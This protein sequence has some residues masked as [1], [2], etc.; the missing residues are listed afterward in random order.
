MTENLLLMRC[1]RDMNMSK[2][3]A[4]DVPLF[5]SLI[6][7][8]FPGLQ[9][10]KAQFPDVEKAIANQV[11]D[12]KS[13]VVQLYETYLVRHGIMII[14]P[15]GGGKTAIFNTLALALTECGTKHVI[16]KMNPKAI[17]A[18][19]MFGRLDAVSNDWTEGIFS[20]LWRK[21]NKNK[22]NIQNRKIESE[23]QQLTRLFEAYLLK[24]MD[25]MRKNVKTISPLPQ[26]NLSQTGCYVL[27]GLLGS[28]EMMA[29]T[30]KSMAPEDS[31]A[32]FES[33]FVYTCIWGLGGAL[34]SDKSNAYR[35]VFDKF[36]RDEHKTIKFPEGGL[37]YDHCVDLDTGA[38]S[39]WTSQV[40]T[41]SHAPDIPFGNISVSTVDTVRL[42][43]FLSLLMDLKRR[44]MF[45]GG[46][47]TGKTTIVKD[48]LR[49][50][51]PD[52]YFFL[53]MN[54]N[55]YTDSLSLQ[56]SME[57]MVE[58]K[59]GKLFGPPGSKKLIYF[60]D[61][62]N[63]PLVDKYGTQQPI[64]LLLQHMDY[65][66]WYERTKLTLKQI[67]GVQY[68]SCLNPSAGSFVIDHRCQR[69][70]CTFAVLAPSIEQVNVIFSSIL[71]HLSV[72]N[73]DISAKTPNIVKAA[74]DLRRTIRIRARQKKFR[75]KLLIEYFEADLKS[76]K[77]SVTKN[78]NVIKMLATDGEIGEWNI[79]GL[80][81]DDL[82]T[83]NGILTLG[84]ARWPLMIDPQGQSCSWI[85]NRESSNGL[86][87]VSFAEK[88]FRFTPAGMGMDTAAAVQQ[89]FTLTP[90][91][92]ANQGA[93]PKSK[94]SAKNHVGMQLFI[95]TARNIITLFVKPSD[96]IDDV[97]A[98]IHIK[99][100]IP[101]DQQRLIFAGK[102]LEDGHTL[103]DYNIK[104]ESRLFLL[105]S[106][107]MGSSGVKTFLAATSNAKF[108]KFN[109][110]PGSN[111]DQPLITLISFSIKLR[112]MLIYLFSVLMTESYDD[113]KIPIQDFIQN[114]LSELDRRSCANKVFKIF[115]NSKFKVHP[116]KENRCKEF[117][118][119]LDAAYPT[120]SFSEDHLEELSSAVDILARG[121]EGTGWSSA[122]DSESQSGT[123]QS[124]PFF[125]MLKA[126][127]DGGIQSTTW[128]DGGC[129]AGIILSLVMVYNF[130]MKGPVQHFLGF[131]MIES[132]TQ[133]ARKL[134]STCRQMLSLVG[135]HTSTVNIVTAKITEQIEKI[136]TDMYERVD[137][138][139]GPSRC[140]FFNN[141]SWNRNGDETFKREFLL[142]FLKLESP[143][144]NVHVFILDPAMLRSD[145]VA[146][147]PLQYLRE[148]QSVATFNNG[149]GV[150]AS[151]HLFCNR[152]FEQTKIFN[153]ILAKLQAKASWKAEAKSFLDLFFANIRDMADGHLL[154]GQAAASLTL[155]Q[156]VVVEVKAAIREVY[157]KD[158]ND[159]KMTQPE[160]NFIIFNDMP[161]SILWAFFHFSFCQLREN[162]MTLSRDFIQAL[163]S[164]H[165]TQLL[166][167]AETQPPVCMNFEKPVPHFSVKRCGLLLPESPEDRD[168]TLFR[169]NVMQMKSLPKPGHASKINGFWNDLALNF[170]A[171]VPPKILKES[172][173]KRP[174][175]EGVDLSS[176]IFTKTVSF[177]HSAYLQ[178]NTWFQDFKKKFPG[179]MFGNLTTL[180]CCLQKMG[181]SIKKYAL[182]TITDTD[183]R[184]PST[185]AAKPSGVVK[186]F[187]SQS[188]KHISSAKNSSADK[189]SATNST[190]TEKKIRKRQPSSAQAK[191]GMSFQ[192]TVLSLLD[193]TDQVFFIHVWEKPMSF[194]GTPSSNEA[195]QSYIQAIKKAMESQQFASH[196]FLTRLPHRF[197][198]NL[199]AFKNFVF[200]TVTTIT[201]GN[202]IRI[203]DNA[204]KLKNQS[205]LLNFEISEMKLKKSSAAGCKRE[206]VEFYPHS[207]KRSRSPEEKTLTFTCGDYIIE[208][209]GHCSPVALGHTAD[210]DNIAKRFKDTIFAFLFPTLGN[211]NDVT[212]LDSTSS[213]YTEHPKA[214]TRCLIWVYRMFCHPRILNYKNFL[215]S[216]KPSPEAD[217]LAIF[218]N[219]KRFCRKHL[220]QSRWIALLAAATEIAVIC[221]KGGQIG[222]L[223]AELITFAKAIPSLFFIGDKNVFENL[224]ETSF[225]ANIESGR[226]PSKKMKRDAAPKK[227]QMENL[228]LDRE[229]DHD[230]DCDLPHNKIQATKLNLQD[231]KLCLNS[232]CVELRC[233]DAINL[234]FFVFEKKQGAAV[235]RSEPNQELHKQEDVQSSPLLL[236][237][238]PNEPKIMCST[239]SG[240]R[241]ISFDNVDVS[242]SFGAMAWLQGN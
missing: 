109:Q 83:Q 228:F 19:Q 185:T 223:E 27:D 64:A 196:S 81:T 143:T 25:W 180:L 39:P 220:C 164:E 205:G 211:T 225:S 224:S 159:K 111:D 48:K 206:A 141:W 200:A 240:Q 52:Q 87:V 149:K 112:K 65:G 80:P 96:N 235:K 79:Q 16:L 129:G 195:L 236:P 14:G 229:P 219:L 134:L 145:L 155:Q 187:D 57:S 152:R 161:P 41:Y 151:V 208:L 157:Q 179:E 114:R 103:A 210:G 89:L 169:Q 6:G 234:D 62:L 9:A 95:Q 186:S 199:V 74:V 231:Q 5:S 242:Q 167:L 162:A 35:T 33:V 21:S 55:C 101:P 82:S 63:M 218:S 37:V 165:W 60:I 136:K 176:L 46:S 232:Y 204:Y 153:S 139:W 160:C 86:N 10:D 102:Q 182:Q 106:R 100:G 24:T 40:P 29:S 173:P 214:Q 124:L 54:L 84:A 135:N 140:Y 31:A 121:Y 198:F 119:S 217:M 23:K 146:Q 73:P 47:G 174:K 226:Q 238:P 108:Q 126:T 51:D 171:V 115:L 78:L 130:V 203:C 116:I 11:N 22:T 122:G 142:D 99:E 18:P 201:R 118:L 34:S 181:K 221:A 178:G 69:Q 13:K 177:W 3:V 222:S 15:S 123:M 132:Q 227:L 213:M 194:Q 241:G 20:V 188:I 117:L 30:Q 94:L 113:S 191:E 183:F 137:D 150:A 28:G 88:M 92:A 207:H 190:I 216:A 53:S 43:Y 156:Q 212:V 202:E 56:T 237:A 32:L 42:T 77:V 44:V 2:F 147:T 154:S 7:D 36:W 72:F 12:W 104:N 58:K 1:L 193:P 110:E 93:T 158:V 189:D 107:L 192:P 71:D 67:Q 166:M 68:I 61:D 144:H 131:D 90:A 75:E 105:V 184:A 26:I 138:K 172:E 50:L 98:K 163:T 17:T 125:K 170:A 175:T 97:K 127:D 120:S 59:T 233:E 215:D 66:E 38:F 239:S 197:R 85:I 49:S 209:K 91:V 148:F 70:C 76:K 4:E 8:L 45:V 230:I 128:I 168:F 133:K